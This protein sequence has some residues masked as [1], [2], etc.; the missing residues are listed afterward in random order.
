MLTLR[1]MRL[2][3]VGIKILQLKF[4]EFPTL[5]FFFFISLNVHLQEK[6]AAWSK[7]FNVIGVIRKING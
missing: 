5:R 6:Y 2:F 1:D 4:T 3:L 7:Y